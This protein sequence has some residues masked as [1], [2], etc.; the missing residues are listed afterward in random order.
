MKIFGVEVTIGSIFKRPKKSPRVAGSEATNNTVNTGN[1]D[2]NIKTGRHDFIRESPISEVEARSRSAIQRPEEEVNVNHMAEEI[3]NR[4]R[5]GSVSLPEVL[6]NRNLI[7][8]AGEAAVNRRNRITPVGETRSRAA[9]Q[10]PEVEAND[11]PENK[12]PGIL[13]K[14]ES[15]SISS[16]DAL[17]ERNAEIINSMRQDGVS[18]EDIFIYAVK[19]GKFDLANNLLDE[20]KVGINNKNDKGQNLLFRFIA[21]PSSVLDTKAL[22]YFKEKGAD[23]NA[24]DERGNPILHYLIK[25]HQPGSG[26]GVK[27]YKLLEKDYVDPDVKEALGFDALDLL[28]GYPQ[29]TQ[30]IPGLA[31]RLLKYS[32]RTLNYAVTKRP[33]LI[34]LLLEEGQCSIE[35]VLGHM[36]REQRFLSAED[37]IYKGDPSREISIEHP[38]GNFYKTTPLYEAA[39]Y[40]DKSITELFLTRVG[41][42]DVIETAINIAVD[43]KNL[44]ALRPLLKYKYNIGYLE[45]AVEA[46]QS[47]VID[48]MIKAGEPIENILVS[49]ARQGKLDLIKSLQGGERLDMN[50]KDKDGQTLLYHFVAKAGPEIDESV[51]DNLL[52][53]GADIK[54]LDNNGRTI[55]HAAAKNIGNNIKNGLFKRLQKEGLDINKQDKSGLTAATYSLCHILSV[56][57]EL[58]RCINFLIEG[59]AELNCK[60]ENDIGKGNTILHYFVE[61]ITG[62]AASNIKFLLTKGYVDPSIPNAQKQTALDLLCKN[63]M[64]HSAT[65]IVTDL[66]FHTPGV[67]KMDQAVED[68]NEELVSLMKLAGATPEKLRAAMRGGKKEGVEIYA[69]FCDLDQKFTLKGADGCPRVMTALHLA[70]RSKRPDMVELILSKGVNLDACDNQGRTAV[71]LANSMRLPNIAKIIVKKSCELAQ[72]RRIPSASPSS[73]SAR[74]RA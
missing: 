44:D 15:N 27:A 42:N 38:D 53:E 63:K 22:D 74:R 26:L 9:I 60:N 3:L 66:L 1:I 45:E 71:M 24:K 2:L 39:R 14:G 28:S 58:E 4:V 49:A 8:Q 32:P 23:F 56:G 25:N 73:T 59:G 10:H 55:L 41:N 40:G 31:G 33:S 36:V 52:N 7:R 16:T 11:G 43:N 21:D 29:M 5:N 47:D 54:S 61:N 20:K 18:F 34:T 50:V 70:V 72:S 12:V 37:Y 51:L 46:S 6:G 30:E 68:G 62:F 65:E 57:E 19:L 67:P 64:A 35:E 17:K 13:N 69:H 48:L